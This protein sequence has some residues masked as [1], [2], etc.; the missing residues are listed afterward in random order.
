MPNNI[1]LQSHGHDNPLL[2]SS[3][4]VNQVQAQIKEATK[5]MY[6]I[7]DGSNKNPLRNNTDL[8]TIWVRYP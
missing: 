3:S 2:Q 5:N 4:L 6:G 7:G 1:P 8:G